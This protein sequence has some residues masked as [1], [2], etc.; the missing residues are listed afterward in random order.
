MKHPAIVEGFESLE[1]IACEVSGDRRVLKQF[2]A[3]LSAEFLE[4]KKK[5]EDKGYK[6]LANDGNL[7][8]YYLHSAS[9]LIKESEYEDEKLKEL[10]RKV[11]ILRYDSLVKLMQEINK[12]AELYP[13]KNSI[14]ILRHMWV[15]SAP[16]MEL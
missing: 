1:H 5:D 9:C 13:L 14:E 10:S 4:Q 7:L 6:M 15:I 2:L 16:H 11:G 3:Y 8:Q 12:R